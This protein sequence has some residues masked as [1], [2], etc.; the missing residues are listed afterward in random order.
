M[1]VAAVQTPQSEKPNV[2]DR[3][4]DAVRHAAQV[5]HEARLIKSLACDAIE[6]RAHEAKRAVKKSVQRG[7]ERLEDIKDES[8]HYVKRQPLKAIA[9]AAGVGLMV[10]IA[11]A[12][13]TSQ[14]RQQRAGKR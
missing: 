9:I 6:D 1:S 13:I 14:L 12:W 10:G 3:I 11:A 2:A 7:T 4:V 8:V 5:S